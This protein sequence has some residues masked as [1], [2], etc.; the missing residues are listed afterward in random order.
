MTN[1]LIILSVLFISL[2]IIVKLTEK[3]GKPLTDEQRQKYSRIAM[4]LM[5]ILLIS[6]LLY[7]MF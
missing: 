7:L 6:Q 5:G 3:H 1:L 2:F 4:V